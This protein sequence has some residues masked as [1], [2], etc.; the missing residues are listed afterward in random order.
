MATVSTIRRSPGASVIVLKERLVTPLAA[1]VRAV[2]ATKALEKRVCRRQQSTFVLI[3][4]GVLALAIKIRN[5]ELEDRLA[6]ETIRSFYAR[7]LKPCGRQI[8][9]RDKLGQ[10]FPSRD[11]RAHDHEGNAQSVLVPAESRWKSSTHLRAGNAATQ[12]IHVHFLRGESM[13]SKIVA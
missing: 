9:L 2:L 13:A 11:A 7:K 4:V 1:R 8:H 3:S 12:N 5:Q 10:L 6:I